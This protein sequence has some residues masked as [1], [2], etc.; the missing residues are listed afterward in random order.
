M[1]TRVLR[2]PR[3]RTGFPLAAPNYLPGSDRRQ[4]LL[5]GH[6]IGLALRPDQSGFDV[7]RVVDALIK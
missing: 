2:Q 5:E 3:I 4:H 1:L 7:D 6:E